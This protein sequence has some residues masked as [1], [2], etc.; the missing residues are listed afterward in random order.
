[1][2]WKRKLRLH[3]WC[4]KYTKAAIFLLKN[5][6][7][8]YISFLQTYVTFYHVIHRLYFLVQQTYI[9]RNE[10][11]IRIFVRAFNKIGNIIKINKC[12]Q[13]HTHLL[14]AVKVYHLRLGLVY[15]KT[16]HI[17]LS[18]IWNVHKKCNFLKHDSPPPKKFCGKYYHRW[19]CTT[20]KINWM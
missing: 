11:R 6:G 3:I 20:D 10:S 1:M 18:Y 4:I 2:N 15:F 5:E 12:L 14:T 13:C 19:Q 9:F 8:R 17:S 7:H 16:L